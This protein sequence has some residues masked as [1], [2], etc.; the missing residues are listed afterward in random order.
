MAALILMASGCDCREKNNED[1]EI[2][3][4]LFNVDSGDISDASVRII[5]KHTGREL[6]RFTIPDQDPEY[7]AEGFFRLPTQALPQTQGGAHAE[8]K[9]SPGKAIHDWTKDETFQSRI[10]KSPAS[11]DVLY[12]PSTGWVY[13]KIDL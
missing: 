7:G 5:N 2:I 11:G 10:L 4:K 13:F 12:S 8:S 9:V 6:D 3:S 1:T